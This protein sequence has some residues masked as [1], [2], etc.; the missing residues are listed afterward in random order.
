MRIVAESYFYNH[1]PKLAVYNKPLANEPRP[2]VALLRNFET[3][4]RTATYS[5]K[6][7]EITRPEPI[8]E[9]HRP[10]PSP[11]FPD[12]AT[13]DHENDTLDPGVFFKSF[14]RTGLFTG[15][16]KGSIINAYA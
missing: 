10:Q 3:Q 6:G 7:D 13:D 14:D 5:N 4:S 1:N 2:A 12:T 15:I 9:S 16:K 11:P 8:T